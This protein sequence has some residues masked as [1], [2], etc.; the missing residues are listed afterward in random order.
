METDT[1]MAQLK[2]NNFPP[3]LLCLAKHRKQKQKSRLVGKFTE[4]LQKCEQKLRNKTP[5]YAKLITSQVDISIN[6]T[7][8]KVGFKNEKT[9]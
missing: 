6:Q 9:E 3:A 1:H 7:H 8:N 4:T 2:R 5:G